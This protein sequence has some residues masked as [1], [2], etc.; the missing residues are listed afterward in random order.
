MLETLTPTR[1]TT[2]NHRRR[3]YSKSSPAPK[4][5]LR[6]DIQ[7]LRALAV[8]VVLLDH[9]IGWPSGGFIGVDVFFVISGFL[10]T[11]LL[12]R[13]YD[14]SGRISF[15]GFYRRRAK[16]ILPA[17]VLVLVTT[18]LAS[19]FV[20]GWTRFISTIWDGVSAAF[21][22][23]N[24]RF[25]IAGND[26]FQAD[27]PV[28]PLRHFWSLAV[29]EQFYFIWPCIMLL[30]ALVVTA[31][32]V[33]DIRFGI[34][35]VIGFISIASFLWAL[36]E[37]QNNNSVAYFSTFSRAWE[38]GVGAFIATVAPRIT[39]IPHYLRPILAWAGIAGITVSLFLIENGGSFPAPSAALPVFSTALVIVAG[40]GVQK[41]KYIWPLTNRVSGYL[42]DISFSLYLWHFPVIII[43]A[44]LIDA[45]TMRG[46]F[47]IAVISVVIAI[48]SYH[49]VEDPIRKSG[50][51]E[52]TKKRRRMSVVAGKNYKITALSALGCVTALVTVPLLMPAKT[53][54]V[55]SPVPPVIT[56]DDTSTSTTPELA[57]LQTE[58]RASLATTTWPELSPSMEEAIAGAQAPQDVTDCGQKDSLVNE[59]ACT[60]G[61]PDAT[62]TAIVIGDSTSLGYVA[63]IRSIADLDPTWRVISYGTFGCSY[64]DAVPGEKV[65]ENC[66]ARKDSAVEAIN[67]IKPDVVFITN[68]YNERKPDGLDSPLSQVENISTVESFVTRFQSATSRIV[69]IAPA[70]ESKNIAKCYTKISEP[71]TCMGGISGR[72]LEASL[73]EQ[74]LADSLGASYV[75][76][77]G[78]FCVQ[79]QCPVFVGTIPVK[80][81]LA[82]ATPEYQ[83]RIAPVILEALRT[84]EIF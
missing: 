66:A 28:S 75:D 84:E 54:D 40:I 82:H 5:S 25:A 39:N 37:S 51:L 42:G 10:I 55:P 33:K 38:L 62:K 14:R 21:F 57:R 26:Y 2:P 24:W 60:W 71:S 16:R 72:W 17:S 47:G 68:H 52:P 36:W 79:G 81:D 76:S 35:L 74:S 80:R 50:W 18:L 44:Q 31:R 67:R 48:Y 61:S 53:L 1:W 22:V 70:P 65:D 45:T 7:G 3:K 9:L 11:G 19:Y 56:A 20:F 41:Q 64:T 73:L 29:E 13:E 78:W 58:I 69:F 46:Q 59:S 83:L 4:K 32:G 23:A 63:G 43:A 15:G 30:I 6:P 27:G 34:G 12:I 49:L 77:R 8:V